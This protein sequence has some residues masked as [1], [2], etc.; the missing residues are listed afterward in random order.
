[1][2]LT[3]RRL[4]PIAALASMI[5]LTS[6][7][8]SPAGAQGN[9][10]GQNPPQWFQDIS[11]LS[12]K[13]LRLWSYFKGDTVTKFDIWTEIG[14]PLNPADD[15]FYYF[16]PDNNG[17][18][19]FRFPWGSRIFS[20]PHPPYTNQTPD[21]RPYTNIVTLRLDDPAA[22][23]GQSVF[24]NLRYPQDGAPEFGPPVLP[25]PA[26]QGWRAPYRYENGTLRVNQK[27]TFARDLIRIE[28]EVTNLGGT[29]RRV[30]LR[31]LLDPF[32]DY[33]GFLSGTGQFRST[34]SIFIPE[35][36]QRLLFE[37][38]YGT[39]P[40]NQGRATGGQII[41]TE[42]EMYDD[43]ETG[44][45][46]Y[47]V[48]GILRGNG[49][50]TPSR[51]I[52]GNTLNMFPTEGTWD[53][54]IDPPQDLL[55]SDIGLLIFWDPVAVPAGAT[56]K[57]VT[58]AG[59]G[60]ASH[61]MSNAYLAAQNFAPP[62][63]QVSQGYI[64]ALQTPFALPLINGNVDLAADNTSPATAKLDAYM[65]NEYQTASLINGFAFLDLPEGFVFPANQSDQSRGL[66]LGTLSPVGSGGID[67]GTGSWIVQATG[68]EAGLLPVT[69]TFSHALG[70]SSRVTRL[71]NVPQGRRY[72]LGPGRQWK[73]ITFPFTF[74]AGRSD[75]SFAIRADDG[76]DPGAIQV[77]RYNPQINQYES[78]SEIRPGES[79]WVRS[80]T[81]Q[82]G[83]TGFVRLQDASPVKLTQSSTFVTRLVRGWNQVGNP[84]PYV[85]PLRDIRFV[86]SSGELINFADAVAA[87]FIRRG[88]FEYNHRTGRYV[89]LTPESLVTPG[90]GIWIF[91]NSER[92]IVW[93]AP[94]GPRLSITP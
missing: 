28:Y 72:Q 84:S 79:Y 11:F 20:A 58:Y 6:L 27:L 60:V 31:L 48:K 56:K 32:L 55:T 26:E 82:D 14:D 64:G 1:M 10:G 57:F 85:V 66:S 67:E 78:V 70:D 63:N 19:V 77:L 61:T 54:N 41:P 33:L 36:R 16:A 52:F 7:A 49:A 75:P 62:A 8:G 29:Q 4:L 38:D 74:E 44:N 42:W 22:T 35:N 71:I 5:G 87:G 15:F 93:P 9:P 24:K 46:N 69:V 3:C 68:A 91:S 81:L 50:T 76:G 21:Q 37:T 59:M 86:G 83:E 53:F 40:V 30:G 90:K 88:A 17:N 73:M 51:V 34:Q 13:Y 92:N 45:P 94:Y 23:T 25:M 18:L 89:P 43:D 39:R 80:L 12:N 65:Q 47:I 2:K